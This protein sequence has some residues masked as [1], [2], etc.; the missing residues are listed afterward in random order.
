MVNPICGCLGRHGP[1][2]LG[3]ALACLAGT[4]LSAQARFWRGDA[5]NDDRFDISDAVFTARLIFL[6]EPSAG[7][8]DAADMD[9]DGVL[10]ITDAVYCV[11]HLFQDGSAPLEPFPECGEDPTVDDI[12]CDLCPACADEGGECLDEELLNGLLPEGL[13]FS[14]CIP[15]GLL[16]VPLDAFAVDVCPEDIAAPCGLTQT[17]GCGV[18]ITSVSATIDAAGRRIALRFEGSVD[19]MGIRITETVFN[20]TTTCLIDVVGEAEGAPFSFEL[21]VPLETVAVGPD[22]EEISG[23]GDV[24]VE[25]QDVR[26]VASGGLVCVLFQAGQDAFTDLIL[27]QFQTATQSLLGGIAEQIVGLRLC[28]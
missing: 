23:V 21:A 10:N 9:D 28:R 14:F 19:D 11:R 5:N 4:P 17:P 2:I 6:G 26:L 20:T 24:T 8:D 15:A 12:S 16:S 3:L 7:C 27:A 25:N 1:L 18:E 22:V 13:A